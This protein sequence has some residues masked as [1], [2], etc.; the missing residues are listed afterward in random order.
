MTSPGTHT[1]SPGT[2]TA[3]PGTHTASPGTTASPATTH[4][5]SASTCKHVASLRTSL[6][7]LNHVTLNASSASKIK[8]DLTNVQTQIAALKGHG[9]GNSALTAQV[10]QLS[11]S[12]DNVRGA[13]HGLSTPPTTAQV[14]T[15]TTALTQLKTQSKSAIAAMN[16]ACPK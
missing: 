3:S 13:A 11:A 7:D 8:A 5:A 2:H 4:K 14:T 1:A 10:N 12:V 16:A 15:I 9:G 6:R